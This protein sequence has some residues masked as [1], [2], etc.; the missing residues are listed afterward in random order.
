ME[1][2][3][4]FSIA[5]AKHLR[6]EDCFKDQAADSHSQ[7]SMMLVKVHVDLSSLAQI[8]WV[9][10]VWTATRVRQVPQDCMTFAHCEHFTRDLVNFLHRR[11]LLSWV[12]ADIRLLLMLILSH[13]HKF[14]LMINASQTA[15]SCD[16]S[17][18]LT[19]H[20]TV[21][22]YLEIGRVAHRIGHFARLHISLFFINY[23]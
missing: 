20:V 19:P 16:A 5:F 17:C 9:P 14:D 10:I 2:E 4:L 11:N 18:W 21:E 1:I 13:R 3:L 15:K 7:V 23:N 6:T 8:T 12:N 22:Q